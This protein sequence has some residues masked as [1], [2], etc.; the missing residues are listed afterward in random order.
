MKTNFQLYMNIFTSLENNF[1][2]LECWIDL[3]LIY[4]QRMKDGERKIMAEQWKYRAESV[5]TM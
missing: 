2:P 3:I 4:F 1:L 5:L